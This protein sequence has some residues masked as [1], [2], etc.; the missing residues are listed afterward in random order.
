MNREYELFE[1]FPDDSMVWRGNVAGLRNVR[2]ALQEIAKATTNVCVAVH[3]PTQEI[4][5]RLNAKPD[6]RALGKPVVFQIAYDES[7]AITR[8]LFLRDL[9]YEVTSGLGNEAAKEILLNLRLQCDLFIVGHTASKETRSDMAAWLK[10]NCP[11]V[12]I[13]GLNPPEESVLSGADYNVSLDGQNAWLS[14]IASV[15]TRNVSPKERR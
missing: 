4:V 12:P 3:L 8:S 6:D 2:F 5:D 9:G 15:V 13:L 14:K 11:G 7:V 1:R 10:A